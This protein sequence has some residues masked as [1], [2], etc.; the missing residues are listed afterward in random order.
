MKLHL[1]HLTLGIDF[2]PRNSLLLNN[3]LFRRSQVI[4]FLSGFVY[5]IIRPIVE[6]IQVEFFAS[7]GPQ[8]FVLGLAMLFQHLDTN[9]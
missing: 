6:R 3:Y 9:N 4:A 5:Y 1:G 8:L 2:Y 7:A